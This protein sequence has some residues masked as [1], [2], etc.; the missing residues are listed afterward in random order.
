[1]SDQLGKQSMRMLG[2]RAA[3]FDARTLKLSKYLASVPP[4]PVE[5]FYH[6]KVQTWP[7]Y[8]ND[9]LGDCVPA[10]SCHMI[11]QWTEY[12]GAFVEPTDAQA[13]AAYSAIG[14]YVPGDPSTDNGCDMLTA[15]NYWRQSGIAGHKIAAFISI[16]PTNLSELRTAIYLFGNVYL[17]IQLPLSAQNQS[18]WTVE[19]TTGDNAPGSWGGHCI[20]L[21]GYNPDIFMCVTWG[22]E[23]N[24]ATD[25]P[26]TY[27]DE[28]YAILTHDWIKKNGEA[29]SGFDLTQLQA[30]LSE[31]ASLP[32]SVWLQRHHV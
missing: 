21:V 13:I 28:A 4:A 32:L 30:D 3:R 18:K 5:A 1:M 2:K 7:M 31:A 6:Q 17:G 11:E 10:A 23:L 25:Y 15:C 26:P 14:G 8:E 19:G 9:T 20:P 27:A 16:D 12:A 22:A 29:P 24:M